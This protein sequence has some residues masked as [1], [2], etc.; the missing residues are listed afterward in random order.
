MV[1]ISVV[2]FVDTSRDL[3]LRAPLCSNRRA[4]DRVDRQLG[5]N[6]SR[7][8]DAVV[9]RP[10]A[11]DAHAARAARQFVL[12]AGG[13]SELPPPR[14]PDR[15]LP[16]AIA[17]SLAKD[18]LIDANAA[19][20]DFLKELVARRD[21]S[22]QRHLQKLVDFDEEGR[23]GDSQAMDSSGS[24]RMKPVP[25]MQ[26]LDHFGRV[27][28]AEA[29]PFAQGP[30][31]TPFKPRSRGAPFE[32]SLRSASRALAIAP[33]RGRQRSSAAA[34]PVA[35]LPA[36]RRSNRAESAEAYERGSRDGAIAARAEETENIE[37]EVAGERERATLAQL[38]FQLNEYAEIAETV[39]A[40]LQVIEQRVAEVV[41]RLIEPLITRATADRIV[42]ALCDNLARLRVGGSPGLMK[43]RG[44]ERVLAALRERVAYLA[45]EV[46]YIA[47]HGVE[48]TI[49]ADETMIR[50]QLQP[51]A[52]LIA[53]L[54]RGLIA[55]LWKTPR[56]PRSSSSGAAAATRKSITAAPGK[57]PS[58]TS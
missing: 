6:R 35:P 48:V 54:V 5:R 41:A 15:A 21:K 9:V 51:W 45:V 47:D 26:Y 4:T 52:D 19:R 40:G 20:D 37:R 39:S 53:S 27:G 8:G 2:D 14:R 23:S 31:P 28:Q 7:R 56:I 55:L 57:S 3:A 36:K 29:Q 32:P 17:L 33:P 58:P 1:K 30:A 10:A 25:I 49:E 43:I 12:A 18:F 24:E 34:A 44:P 11:S 50:R 16:P 38:D 42:E 22:P 13:L 46:E